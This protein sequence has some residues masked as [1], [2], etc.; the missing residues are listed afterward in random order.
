M[1]E[2]NSGTTTATITLR[3]TG[4]SAG[5]VAVDLASAN[6]TATAGSDYTA[7]STT[8]VWA[9][10]DAADKTVSLTVS[11][12]TA[13]EANE[14][15]AL[16]LSNAVGGATLGLASAT[17]TIA[18]DDTA[19]PGTLAFSAATYASAEGNAGTSTA[20]ITI[21]RT[22][23]SDGAV[24]V[25][26]ATGSGTAT[27]GSDYTAASGSLSWADGDS[28]DKTFTVTIAGDTTFEADETVPLTLSSPTGGATLGTAAATLTIT[29]DDAAPA[30][31]S[32]ALTSTTAT[33]SEGAA[34]QV[35]IGVSRT[36]GSGGAVGVSIATLAG[37]ALPGSD[38]TTVSTTLSWADGETGEKTIA[39]PILDDAV[40][41]SS[42]QFLV[43][44][45]TPTGGAV[46]GSTSV[47]TV[48]ILDADVPA[49]Q[50]ASFAY[51]LEGVVP[52][53]ATRVDID[54]RAAEIRVLG[55][56]RIWSATVAGS[57][58]SATVAFVAPDGSR[59]ARTFILG[60]T[61]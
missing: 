32:L 15:I 60:R 38:Y 8:V 36:G 54:G 12:D 22:G 56:V 52:D 37:S 3:R 6:G 42:E 43:L 5:I 27:A 7:L 16:S 53:G 24:G 34:N 59:K 10:A 2:G 41:E 14:T 57:A 29:N 26:Y 39:I 49:S 58:A 13:F 35:I 45:S 11:G 25:S 9:D 31:G 17:L 4:G 40:A 48:T 28:A 50:L 23:G 18:N 19:Q 21:R 51:R 46:L 44:L 1:T 30:A 33:V 55:G 47:A 61:P 20:T